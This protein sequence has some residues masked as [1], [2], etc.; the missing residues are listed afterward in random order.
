[1]RRSEGVVLN[2]MCRILALAALLP[3]GVP[4]DSFGESVGNKPDAVTGDSRVQL[5]EIALAEE[6]S[7]SPKIQFF[8]LLPFHQSEADVPRAGPQE[9]TGPI[10]RLSEADIDAFGVAPCQATLITPAANA[11]ITFP[12]TFNWTTG[13]I[14]MNRL[15]LFS[16]NT[17]FL[18]AVALNVPGVS[19]Q[20]SAADWV[21]IEHALGP[22]QNEYYWSVGGR[23]QTGGIQ[24]WTAFR[25]FRLGAGGECAAVLNVP[26]ADAPL[27]F[28][29]S[30]SWNKSRSCTNQVFVFATSPAPRSVR[31]ITVDGNNFAMSAAEWATLQEEM[32]AFQSEYYWSVGGRVDGNRIQGWAALRRFFVGSSG[33]C[34]AT[35]VSPA[36]HAGVIFPA[37]FQWSTDGTCPRPVLLFAD[38]PNADGFVGGQVERT[39]V[40]VTLQDWAFF[41]SLLQPK[42]FYYWTVGGLTEDLRDVDRLWAPL[43]PFVQTI[44]MPDIR[45]FGGPFAFNCIN[46]RADAELENDSATA[47]ACAGLPLT[48]EN[49]GNAVLVINSLTR[50]PW[51]SLAPPP[52]YQ[53]GAESQLTVCVNV[54]CQT[55]AG[56]DLA[57]MLMI[58]SNDPD[59]PG[60]SMSVSMQC[61]RCG[62]LLC[63][64]E[65]TTCSCP[66][67]C[68]GCCVDADCDDGFFCNGME[69][70]DHQ[71]RCVSQSSPCSRLPDAECLEQIPGCSAPGNFDFDTDLDG[72]DWLVMTFC[73]EGPGSSPILDCL[74]ADFDG[75]G[76]VDLS[77]SSVWLNRFTGEY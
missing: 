34:T 45:V 1:M 65:E 61:E 39:V 31:G 23:T 27:A 2:S 74:I 46:A 68:P 24:L 63:T 41:S 57:G 33:P 28:P 69:V 47:G 62:D 32:A 6:P 71:D 52:P 15:I 73:M 17:S 14:C 42:N 12:A 70:C 50:P 35:L 51:V 8:D 5:S 30:F 53:I 18:G 22:L 19:A 20:I 43:R 38:R 3:A 16:L 54:N 55:C 13:G 59:R 25:R 66:E 26:A 64:G 72:A 48:I 4:C 75:D 76:D 44:P 11:E 37:T 77:D 67:D 29:A 58:S 7:R 9:G 56:A 60:I 36:S 21:Q 40:Q 10:L 49:V